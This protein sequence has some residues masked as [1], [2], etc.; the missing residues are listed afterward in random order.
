MEGFGLSAFS[1]IKTTGAALKPFKEWVNTV[2][3]VRL[4]PKDE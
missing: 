2:D 3:E 4:V 1:A